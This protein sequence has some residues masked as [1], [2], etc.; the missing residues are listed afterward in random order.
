MAAT[1][2]SD[3]PTNTL[4]SL[5]LFQT[6]PR[7]DS[8]TRKTITVF[9]HLKHHISPLPKTVTCERNSFE[10]NLLRHNTQIANHVLTPLELVSFLITV[11]CF[12]NQDFGESKMLCRALAN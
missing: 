3:L 12:K 5:L 4:P 11:S 8:S 6:S 2:A 7:E 1:Y 10:S 9:S